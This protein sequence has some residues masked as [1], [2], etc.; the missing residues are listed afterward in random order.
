M[1]DT[2]MCTQAQC[3]KDA[4]LSASF[5]YFSYFWT[6]YIVR[7]CL[8]ALLRSHTLRRSAFAWERET[9]AS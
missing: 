8:E 3:T 2:Q 5:P 6:L 4:S 7:L 1:A 9:V